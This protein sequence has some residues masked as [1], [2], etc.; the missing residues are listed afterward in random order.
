MRDASTVLNSVAN[1]PPSNLNYPRRSPQKSVIGSRIPISVIGQIFC[2]GGGGAQGGNG[3]LPFMVVFGIR[4]YKTYML[5]TCFPAAPPVF[6]QAGWS[7]PPDFSKF[8]I[9]G[10]LLHYDRPCNSCS[11]IIMIIRSR[12]EKRDNY[13]KLGN[14][15]VKQQRNNPL[16]PSAL[17]SFVLFP[18]RRGSRS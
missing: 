14:Q 4:V 18:F 3:H 7:S 9:S 13:Q 12:V 8:L 6:N 17:L 1:S 10:T 2:V 11:R 15:A 5:C 16:L